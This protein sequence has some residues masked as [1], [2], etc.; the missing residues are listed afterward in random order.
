MVFSPCPVKLFL[1]N[2]SFFSCTL[3]LSQYQCNSN[4]IAH[5][6]IINASVFSE[7]IHEM[8]AQMTTSL[9][10][11]CVFSEPCFKMQMI[12]RGVAYTAATLSPVLCSLSWQITGCVVLHF[13]LIQVKHIRQHICPS[14][15]LRRDSRTPTHRLPSTSVLMYGQCGCL[16]GWGRS[17]KNH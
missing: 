6:L 13:S 4:T 7:R 8:F 1:L 2:I 17:W 14:P 16:E 12:T 10:S 3:H 15:R 5:W 9:T 11:T